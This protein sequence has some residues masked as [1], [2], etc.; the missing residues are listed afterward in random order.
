MYSFP[1]SLTLSGVL[2]FM[3]SISGICTVF[4]LPWLCQVFCVLWYPCQGYVQF[5]HFHD[6][7]RCFVFYDIYVRA[8]YSFPTSMNLSS[9]LCF[10]ISMSGLCTVS[11]LL[12]L[13]QV[14]CVLW[15]PCQGYVQ[16]SHFHDFVKCFVFYDIHVRALYSFPTSMT[17]SGVLCFIMS[18]SVLCTVPHFHDFVRCFVFYDIHVRAMYSFPTSM[19][20]SSDLCFIMSMIWALYSFHISMTLLITWLVF[21]DVHFRDM[22]SFPTSMTLSSDLC[23]TG[24]DFYTFIQAIVMINQKNINKIEKQCYRQGIQCTDSLFSIRTWQLQEKKHSMASFIN[25]IWQICHKNKTQQHGPG[26]RSCLSRNWRM[27]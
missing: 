10:M 18:M 25:Q 4:P 16:F 19:N 21:Y 7:V 22:Y 13:C 5:P 11:P 17:L 9:D 26:K 6:F 8:K 12:W 3:M 20:L 24:F 15:Y 23:F 2:C 27:A 1:T 14:F